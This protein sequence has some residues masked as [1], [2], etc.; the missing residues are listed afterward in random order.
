[1][2]YLPAGFRRLAVTFDN[3]AARREIGDRY[4]WGYQ[5]LAQDGWDV[6]GVI[7]KQPDW[8]RQG[9]L[10]DLFDKLKADGL[11]ARYDHVAMYGASMGGFGALAFAPAAPGCSVFAMAPQSTLNRKI[12]PFENRYRYGRDQGDWEEPRYRDG[13]DGVTAAGRVFIAY[14]PLLPVDAAHAARLHG[15]N[16]QLLQ[17]PGIGHKIPPALTKM[18]IL[19]P[20]AQEA[21]SGTLTATSYRQMFRARRQSIP[22]I[23]SLLIRAQKMGHTKLALGAAELVMARQPH[24]K[25]RHQINALRA[26]LKA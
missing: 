22:W 13:A 15:P 21:L 18:N 16:V 8:F 14:D 12:A 1:M 26:M 19:K 25:I 17:M 6:M 11:F 23:E 2:A 3:L 24:W 7:S 10:L 20:L 5:F 4:P 9:D